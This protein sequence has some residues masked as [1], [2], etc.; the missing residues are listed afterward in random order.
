MTTPDFSVDLAAKRVT[1]ADGERRLT[2]TEWGLVEVLVRNVGRL[3]TQRQV[4]RE[5]WRGDQLPE[6][7]HG[8]RA[9]EAR[10]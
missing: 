10:A 4:L 3:V 9:A 7:A 1:G 8:P 2:P 6:G 5:V